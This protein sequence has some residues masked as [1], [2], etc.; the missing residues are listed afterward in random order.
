MPFNSWVG[1]T[2]LLN[3]GGP[4][5]VAAQT[6]NP[7]AQPG[8]SSSPLAAAAHTASIGNAALKVG[9][10]IGSGVGEAAEVAPEAALAM[11]NGGIVPDLSGPAG[12]GHDS[13]PTMLQPGER[14]I[15]APKPRGPLVNDAHAARAWSTTSEFP[16]GPS[17]ER[18]TSQFAA[19][20][21]NLD[22]L[23]SDLSWPRRTPPGVT[24]MPRGPVCEVCQLPSDQHKPGSFFS[25][26]QGTAGVHPSVDDGRAH[27][28]ADELPGG[29]HDQRLG[30]FGV[31]RGQ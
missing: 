1:A 10:M 2:P 31:G 7:A 17:R 14:V 28:A 11:H 13:V 22:G 6:A 23:V 12:L 25:P 18:S 30:E 3:P 24:L 15:P 16:T 21:S 4:I 27:N 8:G 26:L 20:G 19:M 29:R 9:K 5:N